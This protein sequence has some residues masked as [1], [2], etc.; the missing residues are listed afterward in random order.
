MIPPRIAILHHPRSLAPFGL[1]QAVG[2]AA[3]LLWVVDDT[4]SGDPQLLRILSRTGT[5]VPI[6]GLDHDEASGVLATYRPDGIVSFVDDH[7]ELAAAL[8]ER[9]GLPYHSPQVAANVV[10][11][12]RQRVAL[13]RAGVPGPRFW[14]VPGGLPTD[15]LAC[16]AGTIRY[17]GVL[18]PD[19]GSGSRGIVRVASPEELVGLLAGSPTGSVV[20]EYLSDAPDGDRFFASYFSVESVVSAGRVSHVALTGRFP[21][22]EP[23]RETGN[24]IPALLPSPLQRPVLEMVEAAVEALGI[25]TSVV[26]TEIKLTPEG[27]RLV[28]V[29][30]RLGG[31]PPFVLQSVSEVNLFQVA[32][33]VATGVPVSIEGPVACQ[34]VGFWLMFQP[35]VTARRLV[36]LE[37]LD[38]LQAVEGVEAVSATRQPGEA[39][40]WR[41]G[42]DSQVLT[43]RGRAANHDQLRQVIKTIRSTVTPVY[44]EGNGGVPVTTA[45]FSAGTGI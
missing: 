22:A 5:V 11:K 12:A 20:E 45:T 28:E 30:G 35:T 1:F 32:C 41:E 25:E 15:Q 31:R 2:G 42:T 29:N 26:H 23:F 6:G 34:G 44:E 19:H 40:D 10:D 36:S 8:A 4:V 7:I 33:Q 9:L 13:A 38:H 37:G 27:P 39:V 17:P 3:E 14:Q 24:F 18:K 43:V 16:L 21:L